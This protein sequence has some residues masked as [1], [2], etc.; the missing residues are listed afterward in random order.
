MSNT[1]LANAEL[2]CEGL[3]ESAVD[4][5][6]TLLNQ[7]GHTW[8]SFC[9]QIVAADTGAAFCFSFWPVNANMPVCNLQNLNYEGFEYVCKDRYPGTTGVGEEIIIFDKTAEGFVY[10]YTYT[11]GPFDCWGIT[12]YSTEAQ[13]FQN[14][15]VVIIQLVLSL[16]LTV[17]SMFQHR[18]EMVW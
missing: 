4:K 11:K 1:T 10:N 14:R 13:P 17:F 15:Y 12:R 8:R 2:I 9:T 16:I 3:I 6:L 5:K 18:R 7:P